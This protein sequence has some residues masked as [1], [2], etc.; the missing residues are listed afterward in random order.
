MIEKLFKFILSIHLSSN[1]D[2]PK[3]IHG[4]PQRNKPI[5]PTPPLALAK[6]S[7]LQRRVSLPLLSEKRKVGSFI[8]CA[9]KER[10]REGGREL[11]NT[12]GSIDVLTG[13]YTYG[14]SE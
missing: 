6:T 7:S 14:R 12:A 9:E 4:W 13:R 8:Y 1:N 10:K 5:L 3:N 11:H 2:N